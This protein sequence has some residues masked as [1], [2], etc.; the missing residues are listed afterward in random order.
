MYRL[1]VFYQ[2]RRLD[3]DFLVVPGDLILLGRAEN[4][5]IQVD[6]DE[7]VSRRHVEMRADAEM[8]E[9][10]RLPDSSNPVFVNGEAVETARLSPDSRS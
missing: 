3:R 1:L 10:R 9:V 8:L 4:A 2:G 6:W 7:R 5:A